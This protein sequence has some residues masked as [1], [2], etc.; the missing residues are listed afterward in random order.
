MLF[1]TVKQCKNN[2][3]LSVGVSL[4]KHAEGIQVSGLRCPR[5]IL[6]SATVKQPTCQVRKMT[7]SSGSLG[8]LCKTDPG[9]RIKGV[10]EGE[11]S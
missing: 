8:L 11:T 4:S 1:G 6:K 10:F 7:V 3:C 9:L 2:R 5:N